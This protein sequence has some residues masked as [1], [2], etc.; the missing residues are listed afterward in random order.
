MF[1]Y[2]CRA[3]IDVIYLVNL[4]G[5]HLDA[6]IQRDEVF[7]VLQQSIDRGELSIILTSSGFV[8]FTTTGSMLLYSRI[9]R[10][11]LSLQ[12]DYGLPLPRRRLYQQHN[13]RDRDT[14]DVLRP[15]AVPRAGRV[16]CH[17]DP[18]GSRETRRHGCD[19]LLLTTMLRRG[20][21]I[22]S[23]EITLFDPQ[24]GG[25]RYLQPDSTFFVFVRE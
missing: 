9:I 18:L 20:C 6:E 14:R 7:I 15:V 24:I 4:Y 17:L 10:S 13:R 21:R 23:N 8:G 11:G 19:A 3:A 22:S 2:T 5:E 25:Y 16:Q 1:D 12:G